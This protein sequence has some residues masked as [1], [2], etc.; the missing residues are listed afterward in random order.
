MSLSQG[1]ILKSSLFSIFKVKSEE[2][3]FHRNTKEDIQ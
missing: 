2:Q 3:L 1:A